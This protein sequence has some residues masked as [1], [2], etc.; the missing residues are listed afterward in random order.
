ML[1]SFVEAGNVT[2]MAACRTLEGCPVRNV[3]DAANKTGS[4]GSQFCVGGS[5]FPHEVFGYGQHGSGDRNN[6]GHSSH[7][8]QMGG[9]VFAGI[10]LSARW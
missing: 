1:E 5:A 3:Y 2:T 9:S 10:G 8:A 7:S 6:C 4:I